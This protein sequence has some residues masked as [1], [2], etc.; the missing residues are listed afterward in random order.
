M[1]YNNGKYLESTYDLYLYMYIVNFF[2]FCCCWHFTVKPE[3]KIFCDI[4]KVENQSRESPLSLKIIFK[5]IIQHFVR[6]G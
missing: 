6:L 1:K 5:F 3:K 2:Y 4:R